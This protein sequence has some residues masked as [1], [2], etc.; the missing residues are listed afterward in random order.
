MI[1]QAV[2]E[3][4]HSAKKAIGIAADC[5]ASRWASAMERTDLYLCPPVG[6]VMV[7]ANRESTGN[8]STERKGTLVV[9]AAL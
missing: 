9:A 6:L 7:K 8:R 5:A 2:T 4:A 1:G 3:N